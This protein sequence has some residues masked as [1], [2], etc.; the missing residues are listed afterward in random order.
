MVTGA[1][2]RA[3][4]TTSAIERERPSSVTEGGMRKEG[5]RPYTRRQAYKR[6]VARSHPG[7]SRLA[8]ACN[9]ASAN[10]PGN[11]YRFPCHRL[12]HV[13]RVADRWREVDRRQVG[14]G[15]RAIDLHAIA[16]ELRH[17]P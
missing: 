13:A 6:R 3:T 10:L 2:P 17:D 12:V 16:R 8:T 5:T 14:D 7:H 9:L 15:L 4:A 1:T 11:G